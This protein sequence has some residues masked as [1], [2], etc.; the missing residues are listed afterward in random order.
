[1]EVLE[2]EVQTRMVDMVVLEAMVLVT[3][4]LNLMAA[5]AIV[6]QEFL[7]VM[8]ELAVMVEL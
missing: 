7:L 4:N 6:N 3:T 1:M 2:K 8:V 5:P